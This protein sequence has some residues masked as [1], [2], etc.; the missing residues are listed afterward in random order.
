MGII[1]ITV[2]TVLIIIGIIVL[3]P[4]KSIEREELDAV[5][6]ATLTTIPSDTTSI[7][8]TEADSILEQPEANP[9]IVTTH[10]PLSPKEKG[11]QFEDFVADLLADWRVK[12]LD[13]TQDRMSP[14]GVVA[15]SSKNPD[16]H[17]S[18]KRG[19]TTID[20][21]IECKYL[22]HWN[23]DKIQFEKWQIDRYKEF[24]KDQRRKVLI[25]LGVGGTPTNPQTFML[26]PIDSIHK[27][28][29]RKID[30]RFAITPTT[31]NFVRYMN[32][33]FTAVFSKS[34]EK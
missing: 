27:G 7:K 20:Y 23:D 9:T 2:G 14:A 1:L 19:K 4:K 10:D 26:V 16:F 25:A 24:Q 8:K 22:S 15:E 6:L 11:N 28:T 34:K 13:R 21:Y 32:N 29:V 5:N 33:Y 30:T 3:T 31:D 18:Q 17:I 12:L